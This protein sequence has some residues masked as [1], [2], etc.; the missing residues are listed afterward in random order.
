MFHTD[1]QYFSTTVTFVCMI[2]IVSFYERTPKGTELVKD[3]NSVLHD[4]VT[5]CF[6][7]LLGLARRLCCAANC[8]YYNS[9]MSML[10]L[11]SSEGGDICLF[12]CLEMYS[13]DVC[14]GFT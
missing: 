4:S 10:H 7:L 9:G 13:G 1:I 2:M 3:Q 11:K 12:L 8:N 14:N 5:K 6:I